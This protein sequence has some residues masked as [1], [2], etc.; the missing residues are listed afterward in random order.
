MFGSDSCKI[1]LFLF[2]CV[3][4]IGL[5]SHMLIRTNSIFVIFYIV[6]L[7]LSLVSN[8]VFICY[9]LIVKLSAKKYFCIP[10]I[11]KCLGSQKR[12]KLLVL[13]FSC[14]VGMDYDTLFFFPFLKS[15][16][17]VFVVLTMVFNVR[18]YLVL[19]KMQMQSS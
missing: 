2:I 14:A 8:N 10:Y 15:N 9:C 16:E 19:G 12:L 3:D 6:L 1:H 5:Q 7:V 11:F 18:S 17:L 13:N 4:F